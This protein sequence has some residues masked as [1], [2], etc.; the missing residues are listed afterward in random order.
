[1]SASRFRVWFM[2]KVVRPWLKIRF[3][4]CY[5]AINMLNVSSVPDT[6]IC[7]LSENAQLTVLVHEIFEEKKGYCQKLTF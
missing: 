2:F 5:F 7:K 4:V 1:M 6:S 3:L